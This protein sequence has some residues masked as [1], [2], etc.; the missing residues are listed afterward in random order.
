MLQPWPF[1]VHLCAVTFPRFT[2][3]LCI[4]TSNSRAS[5]GYIYASL[6][7]IIYINLPSPLPRLNHFQLL[8]TID[9]TCCSTSKNTHHIPCINLIINIGASVRNLFITLPLMV[10][11]VIYIYYSNWLFPINLSKSINFSLTV[12]HLI[13]LIPTSPLTSSTSFMFTTKKPSIP[14]SFDNVTEFSP[15]KKANLSGHNLFINN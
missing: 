4:A 13:L 8:N 9:N 14:T 1:Y 3:T 15:C 10:N 6:T 7:T 12:S 2:V 5:Y 11:L